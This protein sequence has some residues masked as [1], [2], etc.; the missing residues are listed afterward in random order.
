[1]PEVMAAIGKLGPGQIYA[2]ITPFVPAPMID[3]VR[4]KGFLTWT[5]QLGAERFK[6]YFMR[7]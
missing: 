3:K 7:S 6:N 1:M 4:E 5:E 2:I